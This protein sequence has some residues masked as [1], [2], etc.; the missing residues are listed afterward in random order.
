MERRSI[1]P[2]VVYR[3]WDR[4]GSCYVGCYS[5]GGDVFDFDSAESARRS[6]C[7]DVFQ[8][9]EKYR[10]DAWIVTYTHC[11]LGVDDNI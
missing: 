6:N 4:G 10:I 5:N 11:S 2:A 7:H 1:D 9:K 3:I 8:D